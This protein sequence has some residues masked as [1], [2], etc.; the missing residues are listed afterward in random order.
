ML[1]KKDPA[2]FVGQRFLDEVLVNA[3][4]Y[5]RVAS[6]LNN[7][8]EELPLFFQKDDSLEVFANIFG[9]LKPKVR[10]IAV[11]IAS[12]LIIKIARQI[13]DTGY[14]SGPLKLVR[15]FIDSAE[16]ELDGSLESYI[17]EPEKGLVENL[18]SFVRQQER[19]AFVVMLDTSYS[20]KGM[21]VILAAIT[22]AA[23]AQHFKQDYAILAFNNRVLPLKAV[24][25]NINSQKILDRLFELE[26]TGDTD[27][28]SALEMGLKQ[29]KQFERKI[30]LILTDGAWNKG[31]D[32]LEI[33]ARFDKLS[34]IGFPPA[35]EE[36]IRQLAIKGKGDFSFVLDQK[37]IAAAILKCLQ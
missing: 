4:Y 7:N 16:I 6:Y 11:R 22:A 5:F 15:G 37:G 10:S 35:K 20:M 1:K 17:A 13:A 12:R 9:M 26:L 19:R 21:K 30:G 14:R 34:V 31:G 28:R 24:D 2:R 27:I 23:I 32:P 36:Q 8:P 18:S 29:V 3:S 25:D 33:A